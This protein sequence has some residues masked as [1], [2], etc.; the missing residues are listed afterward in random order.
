MLGQLLAVAGSAGLSASLYSRYPRRRVAALVGADGVDEWPVAVVALG[1]ARPAIDPRAMPRPA[2]STRQ[3]LEF[4]LVTAA[5]QAGDRTC[6]AARGSEAPRSMCQYEGHDPIETV[7]LA[8][9]S[10]S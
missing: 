5:Q 9:G 4:P 6:S 10:Q 7:V 2:R 3:P 8:R 1:T